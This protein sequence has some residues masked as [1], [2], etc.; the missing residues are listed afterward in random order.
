M[1]IPEQFYSGIVQFNVEEG[2][3]PEKIGTACGIL[4]R[5]MGKMLGEVT[6]VSW[7]LNMN[8]E[9]ENEDGS[10]DRKHIITCI[11][12]KVEPMLPEL[13][14]YVGDGNLLSGE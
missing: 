9:I 5:D 6:G 11:C 3:P 1:T 12:K 8:V 4:Y 2:L 13:E 10:K 7:T 14:S